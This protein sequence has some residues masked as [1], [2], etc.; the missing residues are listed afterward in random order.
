MIVALI[1]IFNLFSSSTQREAR[2]KKYSYA[3]YVARKTIESIIKKVQDTDSFAN[4][5]QN[6]PQGVT[7][8]GTYPLS[9]YFSNFD[10]SESGIPESDYPKLHSELS[11]Y[12]VQVTLEPE[13][14]MPQ[15]QHVRVAHVTV[16]WQHY[17][18]SGND[19]KLTLSCLLT[20]YKQ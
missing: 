7:E 20:R 12:R 11:S 1:P 17:Y 10:E 8:G 4:I 18:S 14:S 6:D 15:N 19:S 2:A 5:D 13:P 9:I 16:Y 3:H